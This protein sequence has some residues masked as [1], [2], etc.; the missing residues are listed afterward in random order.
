MSN[1]PTLDLLGPLSPLAG[2]WEGKKGDDTAPSDDRGTEKNL[3]QE[4]MTFEPISPVQNHE[5]LLYGLRYMT[6]ATRIG[7][8][9][10]FH[11]E[12]GYWLWDPKEKQVMKCF[13]VPRGVNVIAGGS[14]EPTSKQF[15]L[16][17]ELGSATYGI[18]S[19]RFLDREF[20]TV[21]YRFKV[22]LLD[23][24]SFSYEGD[25]QIQLK[26]RKEIFHHID[27]NTLTRVK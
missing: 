12:I 8:R 19:N 14:V 1:I 3:F 16:V 24:N 23:S 15:E 2:I 26:G 22:S 20:K 10:P 5:Q 11:E 21:A 6:V 18:C 27:K 4:R 25:T 17:A 7:E 13:M 9:D